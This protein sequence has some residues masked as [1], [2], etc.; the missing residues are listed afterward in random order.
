MRKIKLV[1]VAFLAALLCMPYVNAECDAAETN[2]LSSLANNVKSSQDVIEK[3]VDPDPDW[4]PPDGLTEEELENYVY[5]MKFFR[6]FISNITEELYVTITNNSTK[7]TKTYNYSDATNGTISFDELVSDQ[8]VN[9][10]LDVYASSKTGCASKK[11]RTFYITTPKYNSL[12]EYSNCEG[13]EEFYLCHEYLNVET[14][15]DNFESL[16]TQYREGKLKADGTPKGED[17][18][19][20]GIFGFIKNHKGTVIGAS[21]AII[22]IGGLVTVI[23]VKKQRSRIV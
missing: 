14:S 11:L 6:I 16:T 4:N 19:D 23:I 1:V 18:K 7:E 22:A 3:A 12:S 10:T 20:E 15:V 17:K 21:I 5:E 8:I 2:K 9:Y 13:I